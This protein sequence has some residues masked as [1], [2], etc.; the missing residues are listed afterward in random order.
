M[1]IVRYA[2]GGRSATAV[3]V[4]PIAA[5]DGDPLAGRPGDPHCSLT[6]RVALV[7]PSSALCA[8]VSTTAAIAAESGV[9]APT[10]RCCS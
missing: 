10:I 3:N 7:A 1:R 9:A 8:S 2:K 5:I 4:R 6:R